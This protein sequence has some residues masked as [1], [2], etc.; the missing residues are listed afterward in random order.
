M[1]PVKS[2]TIIAVLCLAASVTSAHAE[3]ACTSAKDMIRMVKAFYGADAEH[4]D[5]INPTVQMKFSGVNGHETPDQILY[6]FEDQQ[7]YLDIDSEGFLQGF[8]TLKSGSKSGELCRIKD[9]EVTQKGDGDSTSV[10][11]MFEFPFRRADGNF[12]VSELREGAKDGSKIMKGV[13]PGGLGFVVPG[14]KTIVLRPV[15]KDGPMP[16]FEFLKDGKVVRVDG[17]V[18]NTG[19][20]FRLKDIKSSKADTFTIKG[21]YRLEATFKIDPEDLAAAETK[22]LEENP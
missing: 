2:K 7:I 10:N 17:T 11:M 15:D 8:D 6:R 18:F 21:D 9:G 12:D 16:D 14:L 1:Q 5:V 3:D 13:A 4:I 19:R 22:R 20:F